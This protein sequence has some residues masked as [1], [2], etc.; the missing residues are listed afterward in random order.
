MMWKMQWIMMT[1]SLILLIGVTLLSVEPYAVDLQG[2]NPHDA[3]PTNI[4][5]SDV[6]NETEESAEKMEVSDELSKPASSKTAVDRL[7]QISERK[8]WGFILQ[9]GG[10][11]GFPF[12]EYYDGMT[13]GTGFG[14]DLIVRLTDNTA[15]RFSTSRSGI[16]WENDRKY[17]TISFPGS[18]IDVENSR[19]ATRLS[20]AGQFYNRP[21]INGVPE[22]TISYVF[23]GV[24]SISHRL[25]TTTSVEDISNGTVRESSID[26]T[27]TNL[28]FT[29]GTGHTTLI[30]SSIGFDFGAQL[31]LVI[32]QEKNIS[33]FGVRSGGSTIEEGLILDLNAGLVYFF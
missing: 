6:T 7:R 20:I 25:R 17:R 2:E 33:A 12:A 30:F 9:I 3:S 18:R 8:I 22:N 32:S 1:R 21:R 28:M 26:Q 5:Y 16:D 27:E 15:L 29:L 24:G 11:Y 10:N 13:A 19:T 4:E 14:A 31:D 23:V